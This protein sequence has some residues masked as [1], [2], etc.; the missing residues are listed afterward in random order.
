M[1]L[2]DVVPVIESITTEKLEKV[3]KEHFD[4]D[5]FTVFHLKPESYMEANV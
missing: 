2:F 5:R 1:N 3:M 4:F